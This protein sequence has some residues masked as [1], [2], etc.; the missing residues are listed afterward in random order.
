MKEL[1]KDIEFP[2]T[3]EYI[4]NYEFI[5]NS[6]IELFVALTQNEIWSDKI[7]F[8]WDYALVLNYNKKP[9]YVLWIEYNNGLLFITQ[10]QWIRWRNWYRITIWFDLTRYYVD[11]IKSIIKNNALISEIWVEKFFDSA[12]LKSL[13]SLYKRYTWLAKWLWI[14]NYPEFN[15]VSL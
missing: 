14:Y 1:L 15:K 6:K 5:D 10:M 7:E 8:C 3:E 4:R 13:D 9:A 11:C 12:D 2:K